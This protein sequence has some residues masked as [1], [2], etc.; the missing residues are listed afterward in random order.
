MLKSE[1]YVLAEEYAE[2]AGKNMSE[3]VKNA[4]TPQGANPALLEAVKAQAAL[5]QV[6]ATL[7]AL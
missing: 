4:S 7:A 3:F 2:H 6:H 5:A 1:H